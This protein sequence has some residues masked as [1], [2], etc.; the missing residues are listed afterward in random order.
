MEALNTLNSPPVVSFNVWG[1]G[2]WGLFSLGACGL[3]LRSL[4]VGRNGFLICHAVE[5]GKLRPVALP[6]SAPTLRPQTLNPK[7]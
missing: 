5:H 7:P 3:R 1:S 6:V 2:V 4:E